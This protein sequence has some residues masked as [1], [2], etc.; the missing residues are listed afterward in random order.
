MIDDYKVLQA[1]CHS[2]IDRLCSS[3]KEKEQLYKELARKLEIR[4]RYCHFSKMTLS[5]LYQ[6]RRWLRARC[7]KSGA[8]SKTYEQP[9]ITTKEVSLE[10]DGTGS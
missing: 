7:I 1:E 4:Q 10:A 5:Q 2:Y 3:H 6:S 8:M 9:L